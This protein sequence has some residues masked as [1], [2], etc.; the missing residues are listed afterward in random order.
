MFKSFLTFFLFQATFQ[1]SVNPL[2]C[3]FTIIW[4]PASHHLY[5]KHLGPSHPHLLSALLQ[6][7]PNWWLLLFVSLAL[8][9]IQPSWWSSWTLSQITPLLRRKVRHYHGVQGPFTVWISPSLWPHLLLLLPLAQATF[10]SGPLHLTVLSAWNVLHTACSFSLQSLP[11]DIF[12]G[13]AFFTTLLKINCTC[14]FLFSFPLL[15]FLHNTYHFILIYHLIYSFYLFVLSQENVSSMRP[16]LS[17]L[18]K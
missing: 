17:L 10:T 16:G 1:L 2:G 12:S 15:F 18:C 11:N 4:N 13:G 6:R 9:S 3:T 5:H 7:H 14:H 8:L